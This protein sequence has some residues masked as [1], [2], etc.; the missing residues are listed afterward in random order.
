[1]SKVDTSLISASEAAWILNVHVKRVHRLI[2]RGTLDAHK[3]PGIRGAYVLSR[4]QVLALAA[5]ESRKASEAA[6]VLAARSA[7]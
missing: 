2:Q 6:A 5:E 1:M 3:L 7:S 4:E